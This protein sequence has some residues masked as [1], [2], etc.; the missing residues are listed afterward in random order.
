MSSDIGGEEIMLLVIDIGNTNVVLGIYDG[1]ELTASWRLATIK[2]RTEDEYGILL[3][4]LIEQVNLRPKDIDGVI[5]ACV[6]PPLA[7]VFEKLSRKMFDIKAL[8]VGPG[9][10]TGMPILY[11]NPKEVGAD[12]IV[13]AIGAFAEHK[14]PLII[15][16][17]GT[18]T[19]FDVVS[20]RGQYTGGAIAPG[21]GIS[22]DALFSRTAKLPRVDFTHPK[23]VIGKNT[24]DSMQAG[25]YF[26]YVGLVDAIVSRII[27]D[28]GED[29]FVLA[30]GGLASMIADE[31][32]AIDAVDEDITLKGL[33]ILYELNT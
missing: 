33:R 5:L 2:G 17:F 7:S 1:V 6:V 4:N 25:I 18:A 23:S 30:T 13:N 27:R 16:D 3:G 22:M 19:T 10:R 26:G 12:R 31:S 28:L 20:A 24:V 14:G 29:C 9:A 15:V 32:D 21:I 11:D 8:V